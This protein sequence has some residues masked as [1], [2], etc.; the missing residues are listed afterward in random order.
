MLDRQCRFLATGGPLADRAAL[1]TALTWLRQEI[2][3]AVRQ[4]IPGALHHRG[5]RVNDPPDLLL[6]ENVT[7]LVGGPGP[8]E[9]FRDSRFFYEPV[10]LLLPAQL[11]K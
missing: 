1:L 4:Q 2:A 5:V 10:L 3:P 11:G 7:P 9:L 6:T 8:K